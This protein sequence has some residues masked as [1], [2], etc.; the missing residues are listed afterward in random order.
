M[1]L[2]SQRG[3][4]GRNTDEISDDR[5]LRDVTGYFIEAVQGH[6]WRRSEAIDG[7][8]QATGDDDVNEQEATPMMKCGHAANATHNGGP[9][10]VI[11]APAPAAY[12]VNEA[13]PS[14]VGRKSQC[15]YRPHGH[16]VKDSTPD[17]PFFEYRGEGSREATLICKCGYH[18]TAHDKGMARCK[19]FTPKG[20]QPFDKH[21]CG[22][23][24]WD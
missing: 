18:K 4:C 21:Y 23:M 11:C 12:E 17:L 14:L 8:E 15:G 20:A 19:Q 13:P 5:D 16:S 3:N 9:A 10:C 2:A 1:R 22:C 7:N 24:G 6:V